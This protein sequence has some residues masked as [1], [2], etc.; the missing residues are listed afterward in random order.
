MASP[1]GGQLIVD[2]WE[3]EA[4]TRLVIDPIGGAIFFDT[5][6]PAHGLLAPISRFTDKVAEV[7]I[8]PP[9]LR[10]GLPKRRPP[11]PPP[12]VPAPPLPQPGGPLPLAVAGERLA[13]SV[14]SA[15]GML[16]SLAGTLM[17]TPL[18]PIVLRKLLKKSLKEVASA[19][20]PLV[21]TVAAPEPV[22]PEGGRREG[23]R[24][25]PGPRHQLGAAAAAVA[26]AALAA[27]R[28]GRGPSQRTRGYYV[29]D[30]ATSP[31]KPYVGKTVW[32]DSGRSLYLYDSEDAEE[33]DAICAQEELPGT[34]PELRPRPSAES[35]EGA[36]RHPPELVESLPWQED[37][38]S[39]DGCLPTTTCFFRIATDSAEQPSDYRINASRHTSEGTPVESHDSEGDACAH[40]PPAG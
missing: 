31:Y 6:A 25:R 17:P 40:E 14:G 39:Q 34:K 19:S 36:G 26:L 35:T 12:T 10:L 20:Q 16:G 32:S 29:R 22:L 7:H 30:A 1:P 18:V 33:T 4:H 38:L 5:I 37:F 11:Q 23:P 21:V 15:A 28:R 9:K 2:D 24:W 13:V 27:R 3:K 8:E